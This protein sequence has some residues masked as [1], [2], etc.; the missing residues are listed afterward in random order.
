MA[1]K[2]YLVERYPL[3][4]AA[5]QSLTDWDASNN[6]DLHYFQSKE[7]FLNYLNRRR[8]EL[9]IASNLPRRRN[10]CSTPS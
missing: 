6:N 1:T 5:I 9:D 8:Y 7:N 3:T 10:S 2:A 4:D